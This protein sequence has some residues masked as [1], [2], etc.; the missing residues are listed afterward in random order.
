MTMHSLEMLNG[1]GAKRLQALYNVGI[2]TQEQLVLYFPA[3]YADYTNVKAISDCVPGEDAVLRVRVSGKVSQARV[4]GRAIT[5]AVLCDESGT[6]PATWFS[7]PWMFKQLNGREEFTVY[8][9]IDRFNGKLCLNAPRIVTD[10]SLTPVYSPIDAIPPKVLRSLIRDAL[11]NCAL[12][13]TLPESLIS[14]YGLMPRNEAVRQMHFPA[15]RQTLERALYRFHFEELLF[16]M[17]NAVSIKQNG[18]RGVCVSV[19]DQ[20]RKEYL[21]ALSFPL[22]GAQKR[23]LGEIERDLASERPMARLVQGDVGSG[24]TAVAFGTIYECVKD[25]WQCAM[26]APT[27]I[28]AQQHFDSARTILGKI[29]VNCALLTGNLSAKQR[30]QVLEG[31]ES[32]EIQAVF[33]THALVSPNVKYKNLGF[34]VTD[35]QHRFGVRQRTRLGEKGSNPNVLVMSATPIPRTIALILYGDLDISV[36]DELPPGRI[37]VK[38]RLVPE[39]KREDLYGFIVA[40]AK[41]GKQAYFVC[42]LVEDSEAVEAESAQHLFDEMKHSSLGQLRIGL[43]YGRQSNDEKQETLEKFYRGELDILVSTTVIEV[44]VN[45][46]NATVM[47]V[48]N[49]ERFG[50]SQLHQLRGRVGR[51]MDEAWCFLMAN[52]TEKLRVLTQTNDGFV[53]AQKDLELRGPGDLFGTRQ[54]GA[55][56]GL[57][58]RAAEDSRMLSELNTLAKKIARSEDED[59]LRIRAEAALWLKDKNDVIFAAN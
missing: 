38:T 34:A 5:R 10:L 42:P 24:K 4:R 16:F 58:I 45:V 29:G 46:P 21:D 48:E 18:E 30:R 36:I 59:S 12:N 14:Q 17:M 35:E 56:A 8:G 53:I 7:Q 33:G 39:S 27:E 22:T 55:I 15:D 3:K 32:G 20:S 54:T 44:G 52:A 23:V 51:G 26:M 11:E 28:L 19:S 2:M 13:E 1:L 43:V 40:E 9:R 47:V 50:L 6:I 25:G 49:A 41:K 37:P 57:D 31:L